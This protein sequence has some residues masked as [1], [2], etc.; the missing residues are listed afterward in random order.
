MSY[1]LKRNVGA[2]TEN[3][4]ITKVTGDSP[5]TILP[6]DQIIR[7]DASGGALTV[8]L[9]TA[10]GVAGKVYTI[11]RIDNLASTV[12]VTVATTSSQTID[13]A[14]GAHLWNGD[15]VTVESDGANWQIIARNHP[16]TMFSYMLRNS[17]NNRRY[18]AATQGQYAGTPVTS[19]TS[20]AIN[21]LWALPFIVPKATKFDTISFNITTGAA[22]SQ[23]RA[24]IYR[25]NG[26]CYPGALI[27]DTGAISTV[28]SG[29]KDT[30]IT[31]GLQV[32]AAGL[33][34]LAWECD[35]TGLQMICINGSGALDAILGFSSAMTAAA[36]Y[37]YSVAHTFG[38]LPDP[39][40]ASATLLNTNPAAA[41]P[42]PAIGL[43]PI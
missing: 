30:T 25:D 27:F 37:G 20:P 15:T 32:F 35:T 43:R 19:T 9:P 38:A 8:T 24:G 1:S 33:Y 16:E 14:T 18:I 23:A 39:Y 21:T 29:L 42:I 12:L 4:D 3:K 13:G 28:A 41:T 2:Y 34:W 22:T 7:A 10:V 26:N 31:A 36:H 5:Y 17:T 40:T 6:T 11:K